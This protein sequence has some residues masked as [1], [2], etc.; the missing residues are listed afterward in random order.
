M[1]EGKIDAAPALMAALA[2]AQGEFLP[3]A[4]NREVVIKPRES[5]A[6]KFRY[7]DLQAVLDATRPALSKNGLSLVQPIVPAE[8]KGGSVLVTALMHG[9]GCVLQSEMTLPSSDARDP[10]QYGALITYLRRYAVTSLL[11]VAAD[12]DLDESGDDTGA[13]DKDPL[14]GATSGAR[15]VRQPR[16]SV[17][18][19][20][21][22][23]PPFT[24]DSKPANATAGQAGAGEIAWVKKKFEALQ[25][26]D[27]SRVETLKRHGAASLES[28]TMEQ[29][30][31]VKA[32]LLSV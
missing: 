24:P 5:A 28:L 14:E 10:K 9:E 8:G 12:D 7:A 32:E 21:A 17:K 16:A 31:A 23:E 19:T 22:D 25:L 13:H 1:F 20:T 2:K 3:I 29:F 15:A 4:K 11:G 26:D 18:P 30:K 27:A 6:Y